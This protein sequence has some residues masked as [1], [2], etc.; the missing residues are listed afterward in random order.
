MPMKDS[1][2]L[3]VPK[4]NQCFSFGIEIYLFSDHDGSHW[5]LDK[6]T[7]LGKL[8]DRCQKP[9]VKGPPFPSSKP[10]IKTRFMNLVLMFLNHIP[11]LVCHI[12]ARLSRDIPSVVPLQG[13][14][15]PVRQVPQSSRNLATPIFGQPSIQ[16]TSNML[17]R[18]VDIQH[19]NQFLPQLLVLHN[20][21]PQS[22]PTT[23]RIPPLI[24]T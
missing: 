24:P 12:L 9:T 7:G 4:Q 23:T 2:V 16:H 3:R 10:N 11:D 14:H 13:V 15:E 19:P 20:R 22:C 17:P 1:M 18:R 6:I 21:K 5:L 8:H